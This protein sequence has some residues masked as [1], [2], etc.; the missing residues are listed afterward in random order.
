SAIDSQFSHA[1]F[2]HAVAGVGDSDGDGVPDIAVSDPATDAD[3]E[4]RSGATGQLIV[5][6]SDVGTQGFGWSLASGGD[7][8]GDGHQDLLIGW[9]GSLSAPG[10]AGFAVLVSPVNGSVRASYHGTGP[11]HLG[12]GVALADL[13]GDGTA[14]VVLGAD[15]SGGEPSRVAA[16]ENST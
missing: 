2:G 15:G 12:V 13:E 14:D 10:G 8:D 6:W 16:Y 7:V 11:E 4:I 1:D 3:T 5:K 9:P